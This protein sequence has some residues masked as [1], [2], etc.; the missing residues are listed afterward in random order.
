[1]SDITLVIGGCKS[2]K[3]RYALELAEN[4]GFRKVFIAT[5][6]AFD[7]EMKQRVD[8]HRQERADTWQT[9]DVPELVPE[10]IFDHA[11]P[12]VVL[13]VDC[14]TLWINNLLLVSED[15]SMILSKVDALSLAVKSAPCPVILVSN[16]VGAG[17][18]PEN[19]LARLFRD[20]TG[21]ANQRIAAVADR[22][23]CMMAGL[24]IALKGSASS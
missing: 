21:T 19:R 6:V 17:I 18:V 20:V 13:L 12:G 8:R 1:M 3:S 15:A 10:A 5:C 9:F 16:E 24:P 2:G 22:V 11:G 7:E 14:L 4:Y 23:V